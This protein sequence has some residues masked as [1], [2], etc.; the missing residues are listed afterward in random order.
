MLKN[1]KDKNPIYPLRGYK[2]RGIIVVFFLCIIMLTLTYRAFELHVFNQAWLENKVDKQIKRCVSLPNIRGDVFDRNG[3][4]LATTVKVESAFTVP[5]KVENPI[6]LS[7][8]LAKILG[9]SKKTFLGKM[10][11][12]K[13]FVW[14]KRYLTG[15]EAMAIRNLDMEG[16]YTTFENKRYYPNRELAAN[17]L[18]FT[19]IDGVGLE[20]IEYTLNNILTFGKPQL[21]QVNKDG[22]RRSYYQVIKCPELTENNGKNVMLTI[23]NNIQF[24]AEKELAAAIREHRAKSGS[25][26]VLNPKNGEIL[27]MASNPIFNPNTFNHSKLEQRRNQAAG[28]AYEP[29]ST[30]KVFLAA[31]AI[32]DDVAQPQKI[33]FCENGRYRVADYFINDAKPYAWLS[34]SR[35]VQFSS[36]I[37][38]VKVG[39]ELGEYRLYNYLRSFG[40]NE[41]T[42]AALQGE[43][44]GLLRVPGKLTQSD[45][46][47]LCFG[48]GISVTSIQLA[49]ALGAIANEGILVKPRLVKAILNKDGYIE[50]TTEPEML[51]Q[52]ISKLTAAKVIRMME[53]VVGP[54]GTG[55]NAF[56]E[57]YSVAGKTGTAQRIDP[58][59]KKYSDEDVSSLFMGFAPSDDPEL[60][61]VVTIHCPK[62]KHGGGAVAAPVFKNVMEY[63]LHYLGVPSTLSS[64]VN[65]KTASVNSHLYLKT[66]Y[67]ILTKGMMPDMTGMTI[68]EVVS[69]M[70]ELG[71]NFIIEGT[72]RLN[73]QY[74]VPGAPLAKI[75]KLYFSNS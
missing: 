47:S 40:F 22:K 53:D 55:H 12:K 70:K 56:I 49:S 13:S 36:N 31:A 21:I 38:A 28:V 7:G 62:G 10:K 6:E 24:M 27:A 60:I 45:M 64:Q 11:S 32:E 37:G 39:R 20:G 66:R 51:R 69:I 41:K 4:I 46:A 35:I 43:V 48:Q 50:K 58:V 14:L 18:G 19:S 30:I 71:T 44:Q 3:N 67:E 9:N 57:G 29:G 73:R 8:K 61:I 26:V 54:D 25:I 16:V 74:P 65:I 52:V 42:G 17:I 72:G 68:G 63:S 75:V 33:F 34:L 2:V 23:D 15:K 5:S 1:N 59:T